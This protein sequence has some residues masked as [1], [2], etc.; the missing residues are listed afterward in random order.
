[1]II[2]KIWAPNRTIGMEIMRPQMIRLHLPSGTV[3]ATPASERMLSMLMMKSAIRIVRTAWPKVVG[4]LPPSSTRPSLWSVTSLTAMT[5]SAAP[6]MNS[7]YGEASSPVAKSVQ[8]MRTK[9]APRPPTMMALRRI[10]CGRFLQARAM[11]MALSPE[12][13]RSS[14]K[15]PE[16][17]ASH[18]G[19]NIPAK[20]FSNR[21]TPLR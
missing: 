2:R 13:S 5:T 7:M 17:A 19:E 18:S 15:M 10:S 4:W 8:T 1:M 20:K 9:T 14:S 11:R 12:S 6:P 21:F 16:S 3:L